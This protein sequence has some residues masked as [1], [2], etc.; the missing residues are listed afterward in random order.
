MKS[1]L[2]AFALVLASNA[3]A[4]SR[5]VVVQS[6]ELGPYTDP[7]PAFLAAIGEPAM[8]VNLHGRRSE[9]DALIERLRREQSPKV[10][11]CL[12]AKA[13][14]AVRKGL[15][16]VPIVYTAVMQPDRYGLVGANVYGIAGTADPVAFLSQA[17]AFFPGVKR[18]GWLRG[19]HVTD[20]TVAEITEAA[21]AVGVQLVVGNVPDPR[22]MRRAIDD[23]APDVDALWLPA[24]RDILTT[25]TF[26]VLGEETRRRHLPLLVP[27][28]NMV[29]A[30]GLFAVV[31]DPAG[32][33]QQAADLA[34]AVLEDRKPED[35]VAY[36]ALLKVALNLQ[37]LDLAGIDFDRLL[38]DFVDIKIE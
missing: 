23:L 10:V 32:I 26:R 19:P 33:G 8:V 30:G 14:Y 28:D 20:A 17:E 16:D 15:P 37:T 3:E 11:F 36:P 1:L 6:D 25:D 4:R 21:D 12:G 22:S 5:V 27:S 13:A 7:V 2:L 9:A 35:Q 24:D 31:P 38:L 34:I 18:I 29:R